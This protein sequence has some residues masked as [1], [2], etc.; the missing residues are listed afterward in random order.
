MHSCHINMGNHNIS[1][2][3]CCVKEK[4]IILFL[5]LCKTDTKFFP[6]TTKSKWLTRVIFMKNVSNNFQTLRCISTSK[7]PTKIALYSKATI[8]SLMRTLF[9]SERDSW[10]VFLLVISYSL[11]ILFIN[12]L[13]KI[14]FVN[15]FFINP[16]QLKQSAD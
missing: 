9:K 8:S 13:L 5:K 11:A 15:F 1:S 10:N 4:Y 12:S 16:F 7:V 14:N 6:Q 2:P 3:P